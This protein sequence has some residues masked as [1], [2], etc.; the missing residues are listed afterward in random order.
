[1]IRL[2][3]PGFSGRRSLQEIS[4]DD[5]FKAFDDNKLALIYQDR[6]AQGQRSNFNKLVGRD[7][8]EQRKRGNAH[9]SRHRKPAAKSAGRASATASRRGTQ[10]SSARS[11]KSA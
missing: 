7:T 5:W 11:R 8:V 10:R 2:D 3:F 6:T 9:A 4:W 1:M